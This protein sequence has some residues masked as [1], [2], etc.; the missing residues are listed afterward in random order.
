MESTVEEG[1]QKFIADVNKRLLF[2][3]DSNASP[4]HRPLLVIA[5]VMSIKMW[6][7]LEQD[8]TGLVGMNSV[9]DQLSI[10]K[11][12]RDDGSE[13]QCLVLSGPHIKHFSY[14]F[15]SKASIQRILKVIERKRIT[16]KKSAKLMHSWGFALREGVFAETKEGR[17]INKREKS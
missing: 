6:A 14:H 15:K 1:D 10:Y 7:L 12:T 2:V 3:M 9:S 16:M 4:Y 17:C 5:G 11:Y 8:G 13:T